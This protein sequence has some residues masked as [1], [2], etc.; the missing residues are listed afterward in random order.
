MTF[1][2]LPQTLLET[3]RLVAIANRQRLLNEEADRR[4]IAAAVAE[5]LKK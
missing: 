3:A 5:A 1:P 2:P 4:V